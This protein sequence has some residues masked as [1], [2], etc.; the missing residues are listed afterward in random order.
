MDKMN[1]EV[2]HDIGYVLGNGPSRNKDKKQYDGVTYGCNSIHTEMDVNVLVVMDVEVQYQVIA[3]GYPVEH[4]CQFGGWNPMPIGVP[5]EDLNPPHYDLYEY[6][7]EDRKRASDWYYYATSAADYERAV[8]E[9]YVMPYWKPDCGYVCWVS[10]GYKIK[11]VDYDVIPIADFMPGV[12]MRAPSGA[13]ALQEALKGGHDRV[14]VIGFDS[15]AG[16]FATT[17]NN[18]YRPEFELPSFPILEARM[19]KWLEYYKTVVEQHKEIEIIWH[20]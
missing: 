15:I 20:R 13:Y 3:S 4:E 17:S 7:P 5:P 11:E 18:E 16:E 9:K 10:E 12:N 14:E 2:P 6:N 19:R 1:N 8:K